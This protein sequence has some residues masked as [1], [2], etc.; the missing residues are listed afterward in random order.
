MNMVHNGQC[1]L[2]YIYIMTNERYKPKDQAIRPQNKQETLR[3]AEE[4]V[5]AL[6]FSTLKHFQLQYSQ[7]FGHKIHEQHQQLLPK[8]LGSSIISCMEQNSRTHGLYK[9]L[10]TAAN[11]QPSSMQNREVAAAS[12]AISS[13][14]QVHKLQHSSQ[15]GGSSDF[16]G[17]GRKK[18]LGPYSKFFIF[19]YIYIKIEN[20]IYGR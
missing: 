14:R 12:T 13:I 2:Y 6:S 5:S 10:Q 3:E 7:N 16:E 17:P 8:I 1:Q 4:A 11:P 9:H 15:A 18:N 20:K 19:Y